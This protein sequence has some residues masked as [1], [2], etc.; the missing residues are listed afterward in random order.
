MTTH[1]DWCSYTG[2]HCFS[3][4]RYA[5]AL[6]LRTKSLYLLAEQKV[7]GNR[8]EYYTVVSLFFG[9]TYLGLQILRSLL[10]LEY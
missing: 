5:N 8:T 9:F 3:P 4:D 2:L 6:L 10:V 7:E 1:F